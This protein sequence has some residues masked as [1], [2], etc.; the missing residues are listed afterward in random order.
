MKQK[1]LNKM[2]EYQ[3]TFGDSFPT[4]P[5]ARGRSDDECIEIINRC[6]AAKKDVYEMGFCSDSLDIKY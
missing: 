5:L 3:A 6:I 2:E 4:I 1:L